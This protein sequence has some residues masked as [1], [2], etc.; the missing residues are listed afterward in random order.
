M[1]WQVSSSGGGQSNHLRRP[2]H[3]ERIQRGMEIHD[4]STLS[5]LY[6]LLFFAR[7]PIHFSGPE[8]GTAAGEYE[9]VVYNG[10]CDDFAFDRGGNAY[11]AQNFANGVQLVTPEGDVRVIAGSVN[12]TL[13][14]SDA[15]LQFWRTA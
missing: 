4:M 13:L 7:A 1:E 3:H 11:I 15:A 10:P 2:G 8:A 6:S 14:E 5:N 12:S 9:V